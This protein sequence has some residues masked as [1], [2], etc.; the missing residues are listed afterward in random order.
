MSKPLDLVGKR[1]GKLTVLERRPSDAKGQSMWLVRCDCGKEKVVRGHD[2][3]QGKSSSCGCSRIKSC[4]FYEHGL[5]K[6]KLHGLWRNIKDRC[7]NPNNKAY[8]YYGERGIKVC[9]EWSNNFVAFYDWAHA[10]GYQE[11]L[12]IDRIDVNG[13]Y[14][15]ENCRWVNKTIQANNTR[16]NLYIT[17][18]GK[19][20]SL[21]DWCRELGVSYCSVQTRR[22]RGWDTLSA[23][24][25]PFDK[26]KSRNKK[27]KSVTL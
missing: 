16:K 25:T 3:T 9:D 12:Q 1:F 15:P 19:T 23:L 8:K 14:S 18:N 2:L 4:I 5:S 10:N 7:N 20:Q 13:N 24:T 21:A 11:G 27:Q 22:N 17:I 6:N 26:S